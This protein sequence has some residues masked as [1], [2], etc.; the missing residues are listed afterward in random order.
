M[1][2]VS[3][4]CYNTAPEHLPMTVDAIVSAMKQDIGNV[5]MYVTDNGSTD[6]TWDALQAME[7][8]G[9]HV[10]RYTHNISPVKIAN[11]MLHHFFRDCGYQYVLGIP[12]DVILPPYLYSEMLRVPRGFVCASETK[13]KDALARPDEIR[14]VCEHTPMSVMLIRKWAW[15][16]IVAKD[17]YFLCEDYFHYYSDNDLALRM[18]ACG[19]RGAQ[20]NIPFWHSGS[21]SW[22]LAEKDVA[23]AI[24]GQS[25]IDSQ[26][27][28]RRWGFL[29]R[30]SRYTELASDFNFRG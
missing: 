8:E 28:Q 13:D 16:A 15:E 23:D 14:A 20:L 3:L 4:I 22:R 11:R 29:P 10:S 9:F 6:L 19:I 1:N 18:A 7:G 26:T 24:T 12:N 17:G 2:P 27:F 25:A 21:A 30:E 5:G